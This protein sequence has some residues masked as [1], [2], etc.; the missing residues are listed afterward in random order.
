VVLIV[1]F[2]G[3]LNWPD[4]VSTQILHDGVVHHERQAEDEA[5]SAI[6]FASRLAIEQFVCALTGRTLVVIADCS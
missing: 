5:S 6:S 4:F 3:C 1:D 2:E